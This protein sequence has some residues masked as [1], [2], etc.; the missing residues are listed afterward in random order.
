MQPTDRDGL[1]SYRERVGAWFQKALREAKRHTGWA[2][3][4]EEYE[5][6]AQA[7][8]ACV[9]D[10]DR[11]SNVV[12]EVAAFAARIAPAG[13]VNGLAQML[14][15]LTTPGVPDLYQGT[16]YW[17]FSLVDPDNRRPVDFAAR[18][19]SLDAGDAPAALL[20]DWQDGRVKQ[21]ILTRVLARR[22]EAPSLFSEG[23]YIP[24]ASEGPAAD[25]VLAFA[26]AH[27]ERA[28]IAVAARFAANLPGRADLPLPDAAAW[29]ETFL[30]VP[31]NLVGRVA[32][33]VLDGVSGPLP[34]RLPVGEVLGRLPVALLEVA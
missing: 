21:A 5:A 22:A 14:L 32:S 28:V 20:A 1:A 8:L 26:R 29:Q 10:P 2:S 24:L 34:E 16:E 18:A 27:E 31:R 25:H 11:A 33:D 23:A 6:A 17:D 9:L 15:R 4:N 3:P 19:A 12:A 7:F 30:V 13:A